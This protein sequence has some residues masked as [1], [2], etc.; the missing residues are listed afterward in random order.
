MTRVARHY[1][2]H[3]RGIIGD[4]VMV[5]F[6][7]SNCFTSAVNCAIAMNTVSKYNHQ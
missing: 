2:G 4:R 1:D 7:S 5:I 6:D 3:I